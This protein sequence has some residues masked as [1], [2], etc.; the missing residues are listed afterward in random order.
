MRRM[1]LRNSST[2]GDGAIEAITTYVRQ[3][4]PFPGRIT[5]CRSGLDPLRDEVLI[6]GAVLALLGA[7]HPVRRSLLPAGRK[8]VEEDAEGSLG[9]NLP[10]AEGA[11]I[12][13]RA[14]RDGGTLRRSRHQLDARGQLVDDEDRFDGLARL[15]P[16]AR[17]ALLGADLPTGR[18]LHY[19]GHELGEEGVEDALAGDLRVVAG[20]SGA[21]VSA[22][23]RAV[24][25]ALELALIALLL[26]LSQRL[27]RAPTPATAAAGTP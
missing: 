27:Q 4:Q 21:N 1:W 18:R 26:S 14:G 6:R 16:R 10:A 2:L 20:P 11:V 13:L 17:L 19:A 22:T 8:V 3:V 23:S 24:G 25:A 9:E 12:H 15:T 5:T 7:E